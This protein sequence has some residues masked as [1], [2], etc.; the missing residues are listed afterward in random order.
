[1][2]GWVV[3]FSVLIAALTSSG[4]A[5]L[6]LS[7]LRAEARANNPEIRAAIARAR[8]AAES[9]KGAGAFDDPMFM[10]QLWNAPVDFSTV[11]LMFQITQPISLGGKRAARR[12]LA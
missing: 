7:E 2:I 10:V 3:F 6:R 12:E 11:P 9:V 1:M 4:P 8:A 5:P